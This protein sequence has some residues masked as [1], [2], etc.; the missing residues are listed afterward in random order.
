V[1]LAPPVG[2]ET[3]PDKQVEQP[4][5]PSAEWVPPGQ[6]KQETAPALAEKVPARQSVQSLALAM[7]DEV[8]A[9]QSAQIPSAT[10]LHAVTRRVPGWQ[11][12]HATQVLPPARYRLCGQLTQS[13]TPGPV[14]VAQLASQSEQIRSEPARQAVLSYVPAGHAPPQL[15]HRMP[16]KNPWAPQAEH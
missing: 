11:S 5:A 2:P 10:G 3:V 14:Q 16:S 9:L 15:W 4:V 8:P 7:P 6:V 13:L 12:V 1:Q